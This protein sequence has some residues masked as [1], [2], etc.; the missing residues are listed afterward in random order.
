VRDE[1]VRASAN[2]PPSWKNDASCTRLC[3]RVAGF[4]RAFIQRK[5]QF[6]H[7]IDY[8]SWLTD[9]SYRRQ[10][11]DRLVLPDAPIDTK[12]TTHGG[13]SS[14][15]GSAVVDPVR[16]LHRFKP[17]EQSPLFLSIVT[18]FA[19]LYRRYY[20]QL[21]SGLPWDPSL[22]SLLETAPESTRSREDQIKASATKQ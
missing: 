16:Q 4:T 22:Q 20:T 15:S 6:D 17:F 21:P 7:Y 9:S 12:A 5:Q 13:G 2:C 18:S 3:R 1:E 8:A 19:R 10:V 14:F 11:A